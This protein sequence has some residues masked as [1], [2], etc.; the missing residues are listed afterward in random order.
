MVQFLYL[1]FSKESDRITIKMKNFYNNFSINGKNAAVSSTPI[2]SVGF[3]RYTPY[4]A[5]IKTY[6]LT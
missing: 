2:Y 1:L 3:N 5:C 6:A 4:I